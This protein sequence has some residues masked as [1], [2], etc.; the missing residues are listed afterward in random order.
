MGEIER[1]QRIIG[2]TPVD[3]NRVHKADQANKD[4]RHQHLPHSEEDSI[5]LTFEAEAPVAPPIAPSTP[6][7]D[8]LD[9][10]V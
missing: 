7:E 1:V 8:H 5:E 10:A 4:G 6:G 9:I 3:P 2:P